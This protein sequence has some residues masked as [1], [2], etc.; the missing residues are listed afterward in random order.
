MLSVKKSIPDNIGEIKLDRIEDAID[1]IRN[2]KLIIV[3]DDETRENEGDFICAAEC[4]TPDMINFMATNGRGL[5]CTPITQELAKTLELNSMVSNNTAL[6]STAFTI[7]IDYTKKGCTT[8]ISAYDRATGIK[9]MIDPNTKADDFARPGHIFPLI[10]K[11]GGVL[12]RTGHT[13]AAVD[14]AQLAGFKQAGV[15][16]E[17]LNEDGSM[18]RLPELCQIARKFNLKIISI[19]DLI[20]YKLQRERLIKPVSSMTVN[21]PHGEFELVAYKEEGSEQTHLVLKKGTWEEDELVLTRVHSGTN[22][23]ELFASFLTDGGQQITKAL[24][25]ISRAGKG[26]LIILQY[27]DLE[28]SVMH[29]MKTLMDYQEND[30]PLNPYLKR[31]NKPGNKE[32]GIGAQI[33]LDLKIRKVNLLTNSN[34][35]P[36]LHGYNIEIVETTS[37]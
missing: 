8:G 24:D 15:L 34:F 1:D 6:H 5:I 4:V 31:L 17:I 14:I 22:T 25:T 19:D 26:A 3:V 23:A 2:G 35:R 18:A 16:V 9:A 36:G 33:L 12:R 21:T 32:I 10:A 11:D 28:D 37:F 13:E 20:D 30:K 7:S 27:E 29:T